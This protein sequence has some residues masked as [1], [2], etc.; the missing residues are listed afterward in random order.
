MLILSTNYS[1]GEVGVGKMS[2]LRTLP[3][4]HRYLYVLYEVIDLVKRF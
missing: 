2:Y 4:Y 1:I 3:E